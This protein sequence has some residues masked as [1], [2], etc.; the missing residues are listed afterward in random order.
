[1][2]WPWAADGPRID[3]INYRRHVEDAAGEEGGL[4][5]HDPFGLRGSPLN[6]AAQDLAFRIVTQVCD[7]LKV[8][9]TVIEKKGLLK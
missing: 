9:Y 3:V 6:G 2:S 5:L 1:M 8:K 4:R 7:E